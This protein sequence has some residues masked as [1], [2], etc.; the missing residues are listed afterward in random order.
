MSPIFT[1]GKLKMM[2]TSFKTVNEEFFKQLTQ[3]V[4]SK[5]RDGAYSM[6]MRQ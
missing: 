3:I 6:D 2:S 5:G 1:T 4:D